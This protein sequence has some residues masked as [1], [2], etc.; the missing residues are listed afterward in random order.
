MKVEEKIH[1]DN[2]DD[3]DEDFTSFLF[4]FVLHN[5]ESVKRLEEEGLKVVQVTN[6]SRFKKR[7]QC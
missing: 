3:D 7:N 6:F 4:V 5:F 2:N 1:N